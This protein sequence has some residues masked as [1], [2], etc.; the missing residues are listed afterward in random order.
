M[1]PCRT[2][3][4]FAA[5]LSVSAVAASA[6]AQRAFVTL[7]DDGTIARRAVRTQADIQAIQ[8]TLLQLYDASGAPRPEILSVWTTFPMGGNAISTYYDPLANDVRGIGMET[9]FG[10]DGLLDSAEPPIRCILFHNDVT[11]MRARA[12]RHDAPLDGYAQYAFL[13]ELSHLWGPAVQ[14]PGA[15][16]GILIGFRFHWSFWMDAGGSPA[17][18]NLWRDNADGTFTTQ[19]QQ[20]GTLRFSML[21]LYVMGLADPS[22]VTPFGVLVPAAP[23]VGPVDRFRGGAL[24]AAS[25]PWFSATPVTVTATRRTFTINDVIM[26]NGMRDPPRASSPAT[27]TLGIVL[28]VGA[29]ATDTDVAAAETLFDPIASQFAP[30]FHRATR[31]RGTLR[32]VTPAPADA[33]VTDAAVDDAVD[34]PVESGPRDG[35]IGDEV[36]R[37][38]PR[39]CGCRSAGPRIGTPGVVGTAVLLLIARVGRRS[40]RQRAARDLRRTFGT[41]RTPM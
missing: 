15:S 41:Q 23:P 1:L 13:L 4:A 11:Q 6:H 21:D 14:V 38:P 27:W 26:Q 18:G 2:V 7:R 10:L 12:A 40:R 29:A 36:V 19:A 32:V 9:A 34:A 17:G 37:P 35:M 30:T 31:D 8:T 25:F 16:R 39:G 24:T 22:E 28:L 33:G 5:L 3:V 20:P